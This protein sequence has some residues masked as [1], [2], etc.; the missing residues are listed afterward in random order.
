MNSVQ[1]IIKYLAIAFAV[2][3]IGV[4][5]SAVVGAGV[6][7]GRIFTDTDQVSNADWSDVTSVG[8]FSAYENFSGLK[9][10]LK[11]TSL[12]I[13]RGEKFEILADDTEVKVHQGGDILYVAEERDWFDWF[14]G[15]Q[16]KIRLPEGKKLTEFIL[17]AGAGKVEID[18]L[19][20]EKLDLS[21]GAG[22]VELQNVV[23]ISEAKIDGG[24]GYLSL[25][26]SS[27]KDLDLD[28]G[29][30]KVEIEAELLGRSEIDAGVGHLVLNLYGRET[31]YKVRVDKGLGAVKFNGSEMSDGSAHGDGKNEIKI[32]GGVGAIDITTR[33][34]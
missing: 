5:F 28:M 12:R 8:D 24:A 21:L 29:A 10:E 15:G 31:D 33:D 13:E 22:R 27:L 14:D 18:G 16:L 17:D 6:I 3:L 23:V 1:K 19:H 4:V 25:S 34:R 26:G 32:D 9:L 7:V 20:A 30:G 2:F 11:T